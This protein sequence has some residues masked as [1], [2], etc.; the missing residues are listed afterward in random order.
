MVTLSR[1]ELIKELEDEAEKIHNSTRVDIPLFSPMHN[2]FR[3][4]SETYYKWSISPKSNNIHKTTAL[5][6]I[7]SVFFFTFIQLIFPNLFISK[8]EKAFAGNYQFSWDSTSHF[9][10]NGVDG[11]LYTGA[12]TRSFVDTSGDKV[13]IERYNV[14]NDLLKVDAGYGGYHALAVKSDNT[15]WAWGSDQYGALGNGYG[16]T[17]N[18]PIK[19]NSISGVTDVA[20]GNYF[21]LA[22]KSDGTVWAWG[23]N[24]NGQLGNNSTTSSN[25]PVQVSGLTGVTA[26]TAGQM[27]GYALKSD[28]TVWAWGYNGLYQLGNGNATQQLVPVQVSSLT[29]VTKIDSYNY[30]VLALKSDGTVW[31]WGFNTSGQL[32]NNTTT[33]PT[34]R[35]QASGLTGI[36]DIAAG[37]TSSYAVKSDGTAYAWG[38][39]SYGKLADNSTTQRLTP[40]LS[41]I[42]GVIDI[43]ASD[44]HVSF[45]KNDGSLWSA[46]LNNNG[47]FGIGTTSSS[48]QLVP[49][50]ETLNITNAST[51]TCT[52]G[53]T[54]VKTTAGDLKSVG[55]NGYG[56]LGDGT[57]TSR[58]YLT[59]TRKGLAYSDYNAG[60]TKLDVSE[61]SSY[62][63]HMALKGDGTV[64]SWGGSYW[65]MNGSGSPSDRSNIQSVAN[66]GTGVDISTGFSH[67]LVLKSDGTVWSSGNN[68]YGQLGN[69]NNTASNIP[70][71]VSNLVNV[72]AVSAAPYHSY[73]LKQDGTVWAWGRNNTGQLGDNSTNNSNIPVQVSGLTNV[74]TISSGSYFA[75]A[76]KQ[77]GT[78]WSWG[79]NA[80]GQLGNNSTTQSNVPVQVSNISNVTAVS[81]GTGHSLA[82]KSDGTVWSWGNN[83]SG[84]LGNGNT[85]QSLV[86]VQTSGITNISKIFASSHG[87]S[88]NYTSFAVTNSGTLYGWGE[89]GSYLLGN[90]TTVDSLVPIVVNGINNVVDVAFTE[91][92]I[93]AV[94]NTGQIWNWAT[95]GQYYP[96]GCPGSSITPVKQIKATEDTN[97]VA[98]KLNNWGNITNLKYKASAKVSW[99]DFYWYSLSNL[100]SSTSLQLRFRTSDNDST[101]SSW[102]NF[103]TFNSGSS[104][105]GLLNGIASSYYLEIE[106]LL[107]SFDQQTNIELDRLA[108]SYDYIEAPLNSNIYLKHTDDSVIK[109]DLGED[110]PGGI[111]GGWT[112]ETSVKV[113]VDGLGCSG[114]SNSTNIRP[115]VEIKPVSSFGSVFDG[116][117]NI[118][119]ASPGNNFVVATSLVNNTAY[120]LRVRAIDDQGRVSAWTTYDTN[121][122]GTNW[123]SDISATDL[124]VEQTSPTGTLTVNNGSEFGSRYIPLGFTA[125]ETGGSKM[126]S[127]RM[128]NDGGSTWSNWETLSWTINGSTYSATKD[129]FDTAAFGGTTLEGEKTIIAEIKDNAGNT[130]TSYSWNTAND[131]NSNSRTTG[132]ATLNDN[133][134]ISGNSVQLNGDTSFPGF[135][136]V[137]AGGEFVLGLKSDGTVWSWGRNNYGQLGNNTTTNSNTPVQASGLSNIT[138]ISAGDYHSLARKSDGTAWSWG[139]NDNGQLGINN[140]TQQNIPVQIT[141]LSNISSLDA[142]SA[143][144][145]AINSSGQL[146]MWGYN[147]SGQ[148]GNNSTTQ[149]NVPVLNTYISSLNQIS[150]GSS[151]SYAKTTAGAV[152]AWGYNSTQGTLCLNNTTG[153]YLTPQNTNTGVSDIS[154]GSDT[155]LQLKSGVV[156]SCGYNGS[157]Y[158]LGQPNLYTYYITETAISGLSN[159]TD[160]EM[161]NDNGIAKKS[162]GTI[163]GWGNPNGLG[164]TI[165][166]SSATPAQVTAAAN[167]TSYGLG[168]LATFGVYLHSDG[169]VWSN[170]YN[171]YG[172]LGNFSNIQSTVDAQ[173]RPPDGYRYLTQNGSLSKLY[174]DSGL[175]SRTSWGSISWVQTV[176]SGTSLKVMTRGTNIADPSSATV[177]GV[178]S[179]GWTNWNEDQ[180]GASFYTSGN[181]I[182]TPATRWLEI[183]IDFNT[184]QPYSTAVL[185]SLALS[186]SLSG[187]TIIDG[188]PPIAASDALIAPN[189]GELWP[190]GSTNS[191]LWD[192]SKIT[193]GIALKNDG[194]SAISLEYNMENGSGPWT[195]IASG[196][197][198]GNNSCNPDPGTGCYVWTVPNVTKTQAL[199]RIKA[200]DKA[201]NVSSPEYS[202]ATFAILIDDQ[203]PYWDNPGLAVS[204]L[205]TNGGI[206]FTDSDTTLSWNAGQDVQPGSGIVEYQLWLKQIGIDSD[207]VLN[208]AA[209]NKNTTSLAVTLGEGNWQWKVKAVDNAGNSAFTNTVYDMT[210]DNTA[211]TGSLLISPL[212]NY[213]ITGTKVSNVNVST[214]ALSDSVS[215]FKDISFSN[216]NTGPWTAFQTS[217]TYSS[218]DLTNSSYGGDTNK[219]TKNIYARLRDNVGNI[220]STI[221][222][223]IVYEDVAPSNPTSSISAT[224]NNQSNYTNGSW[225]GNSTATISWAVA[226]DAA[227][228]SGIYNYILYRNK[229]NTD[230]NSATLLGITTN[231]SYQDTSLIDGHRY[232]YWVGAQDNAQNNSAYASSSYVTVDLA[233]VTN[234]E[235][236]QNFNAVGSADDTITVSWMSAPENS[237]SRDGKANLYSVSRTN[238]LGSDEPQNASTSY[239]YSNNLAT[240]TFE[241]GTY[242]KGSELY[243]FD[244]TVTPQQWYYYR[245]RSTDESSR[246]SS[247]LYYKSRGNFAPDLDQDNNGSADITL[248]VNNNHNINNVEPGDIV[249]VEFVA[250]DAD[251]RDDLNTG[252]ATQ[253]LKVQ[254]G[255]L[256]VLLDWTLVTSK[257]D[258]STNGYTYSYSYTVPAN[259]NYGTYTIGINV[260]D[261]VSIGSAG[262]N[263][264]NTLDTVQFKVPPFE[265]TNLVANGYTSTIVQL[266]WSAPSNGGLRTLQTYSVERKLA[267]D[268]DTAY[269]QIALTSNNNLTDTGRSI[270]TSYSYRVRAFDVSG[271]IG[272]YSAVSQAT[273]PKPAKPGEATV[274]DASNSNLAYGGTYPVRYLLSWDRV[275]SQVTP[276]FKGY[277]VFRSTDGVWD[278]NPVASID[279][280]SLGFNQTYFLDVHTISDQNKVYEYRIATWDQADNTGD[281]VQTQSTVQT[282]APQLVTQPTATESGVSWVKLT[283]KSNQSTTGMVKYR[284]TGQNDFISFA[285]DPD[286]TTT[287]DN[288][289]YVHTTTI[290]GLDKG[291]QYNFIV[292]DINQS[293]LLSV[294][295]NE[296]TAS[297]K[298]FDISSISKATTATGATLS[299][300]T[301]DITSEGYVEYKKG[302]DSAKVMGTGADS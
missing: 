178:A 35:V 146:Y 277:K 13:G 109:N 123:F 32:G 3:S 112:N 295:S 294:E 261:S 245:I 219:G 118:F 157:N 169:T 127:V 215:G 186:Y 129:G 58:S 44:Y 222:T 38:D 218:W 258:Y 262:D 269:S 143:H 16:K 281:T 283:W 74:S 172:Q 279:C 241:N 140:T 235:V 168:S 100:T 150:L 93:S 137:S 280:V 227:P 78:V 106:V 59:N 98:S 65:Q 99:S 144:S 226:T 121:F 272:K 128:S 182:V 126:G 103:S 228:S 255:T 224:Q 271:N 20:V 23:Y 164:S 166:A 130:Q 108:V 181:N 152:Y 191:I 289:S 85:T 242:Y 297:T 161:G 251:G 94:D 221:N 77:D 52:S 296:I 159:V 124:K 7:F 162:D 68:D 204:P 256:D 216:S 138:D 298:S 260:K 263:T 265:P 34:T 276:D 117:S 286:V 233:D 25:I 71:Q 278:P 41:S 189:G 89:N 206:N 141:T 273:T 165:T 55:Y 212:T 73:A 293:K 285:G 4:R 36:I 39:N 188:T 47:Q 147:G 156:Y 70:V 111:A 45:L 91:S 139:R 270:D 202:N 42:T 72:L 101:W 19:V 248:S 37:N 284:K 53:L 148:L 75:L 210:I 26:I 176:P 203:N 301:G 250:T 229:D 90:G 56:L 115:Q 6:F 179:T 49:I 27:S 29:G 257:Q 21:S 9:N 95:N 153:Q 102:S 249:T 134:R 237:T 22:L 96:W 17:E 163:W 50:R 97:N 14:F 135:S 240:V 173:L 136:K 10:N 132:T 82:L 200:E 64:L 131:F 288:G 171:T 31:G 5:G 299:W 183:K 300:S 211:P 8:L 196:L 170:G 291:T 268:N 80:S 198:N 33:T 114:C 232:Y 239:T 24:S 66:W 290:R 231:T 125:Y 244:D 185:S 105:N 197:N 187:T 154:A 110:L 84:Q 60:V 88:T 119:T 238:A 158:R 87:N 51:V 46:G 275:D 193:D 225:V 12:T 267:S 142:G 57:N 86:P 76:V 259:A 177:T 266:T 287:L 274:K 201:G 2:Y 11:S 199:V 145:G 213:G 167:S 254:N 180:S 223:S 15:V 190:G 236:P 151:F 18:V 83:S 122:D 113:V 220:S 184:T 194:L 205:Y 207:F 252:N 149:S 30:H 160:V 195:Q 282:V 92:T 107:V 292:M 246:S 217:S 192:A 67:T 243:S 40:V 63:G 253:N 302:N 79:M 116:T 133:I 175:N 230:V 62:A 69:G 264:H 104:G 61:Y 209:I 247:Y 155:V 214:N 1:D 120:H 54:F 234:P 174:V 28:G 43:G 81:G 48:N 208:T